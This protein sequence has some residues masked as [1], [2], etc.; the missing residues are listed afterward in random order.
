MPLL[1]LHLVIYILSFMWVFNELKYSRLRLLIIP[2]LTL[3]NIVLGYLYLAFIYSIYAD[4]RISAFRIIFDLFIGKYTI[5][6]VLISSL[7]FY[8][9]KK[10]HKRQYMFI[11]IVFLMTLF[12]T[13]VMSFVFHENFLVQFNIQ[14][15]Y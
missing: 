6:I 8:V 12:P 11:P 3:L 13:I 10:F 1:L 15:Y 5:L 2:A 14:T 4:Q 7:S 9:L